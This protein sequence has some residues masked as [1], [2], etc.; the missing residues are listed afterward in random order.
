MIS[1][2]IFL[3]FIFIMYH[4]HITVTVRKLTKY[5]ANVLFSVAK[6]KFVRSALRNEASYRAQQ[7]YVHARAAVNNTRMCSCCNSH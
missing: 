6:Y 4:Y 5:V 3:L 7:Y 2:S 1:K